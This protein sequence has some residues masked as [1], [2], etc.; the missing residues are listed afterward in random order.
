MKHGFRFGLVETLLMSLCRTNALSGE[1]ERD[2][3]RVE[4][5]WKGRRKDEDAILVIY[6][7]R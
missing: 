3:D 2:E 1:L 7:W 4:K 6:I 5:R